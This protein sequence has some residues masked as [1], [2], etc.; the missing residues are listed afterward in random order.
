MTYDLLLGLITFAFV[1]S[2][3]PGPNNLMLMASGANFGFRRTLPHMVGISLGHAFMVALVGLGL[4]Q[5][6]TAF[7]MA[8]FIMQW[9]STLYLLYLAWKIATAAPPSE[10]NARGRPF[11][12]LQAAAFQW[13]NPKAWYMAIYAVTNY[14]PEGTGLWP[15][16]IVAGV[17][18][19][20]N[21]P[22][23]AV[24]A[25]IGTQIKRL[26]TRPKLLRWFNGTMAVLLVLTLIPVWFST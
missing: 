26:L 6:F 5:I 24:W 8:Q 16:F 3:T 21:Q 20:T 7:P 9:L 12:F 2:I 18:A 10:G 13:V 25:G 15:I 17:F 14:T 23:V 1:S 4:G 22:S 19:A 11:T